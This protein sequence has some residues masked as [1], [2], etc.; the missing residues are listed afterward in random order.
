ML[1]RPSGAA[2][3]AIRN[4]DG[5]P[6]RNKTRSGGES[7]SQ[8]ARVRSAGL[9]GPRRP[10]QRVPHRAP[11]GVVLPLLPPP[12][13]NEA[14]GEGF[15]RRGPRAGAPLL[16][17]PS[18]RGRPS[19]RR[20]DDVAK[21]AAD[22]WWTARSEVTSCLRASSLAAWAA[23]K[24][25]GNSPTETDEG[26]CTHRTRAPRGAQKLIVYTTATLSGTPGYGSFQRAK[27]RGS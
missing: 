13:R 16:D 19:P 15:G 1:A 23:R 26:R 17:R 4:G 7:V 9:H 6:A 24:I 5:A 27:M 11:A 14:A 25:S 18:E 21:A 20:L 12:A 10:R 3:L 2:S 22:G 8:G